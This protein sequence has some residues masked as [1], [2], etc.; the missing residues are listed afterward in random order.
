MA[1]ETKA[2][3]CC[4][5]CGHCLGGVPQPH[6]VLPYYVPMPMPYYRPALQP[7]YPVTWPWTYTTISHGTNDLTDGTSPNQAVVTSGYSQVVN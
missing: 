3:C 1:K 5:A 2:P 7:A 4:P 6:Q